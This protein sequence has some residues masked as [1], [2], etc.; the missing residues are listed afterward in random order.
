MPFVRVYIV[1]HGETDANRQ[2]IIQGQLDT[3]LNEQGYQQAAIVGEYLKSIPFTAAF[4]SD[5]QRAA[6]VRCFSSRDAQA[7]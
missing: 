3:Q 5:A 7:D 6:N 2:G 4:T 1:R